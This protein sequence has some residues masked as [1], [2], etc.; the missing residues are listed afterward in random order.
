MGRLPVSNKGRLIV[1]KERGGLR[2]PYSV[3]K[4][5]RAS[6][7]SAPTT[8]RL[9]DTFTCLKM[10]YMYIYYP[11]ENSCQLLR[12]RTMV[13]KSTLFNQSRPQ[14]FLFSFTFQL[15]YSQTSDIS[16]LILWDQWL[17]TNFEISRRL[18]FITHIRYVK[19]TLTLKP[20]G[21]PFTIH[22]LIPYI[23]FLYSYLYIFDIQHSIL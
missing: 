4:T 12:S 16:K 13:S 11:D 20:V 3:P 1:R 18:Y 15:L 9:W 21:H 19:N 23:A 2:I 7:P 5:Q 8:I 22:S 17:I 10:I 6:T 14:Y